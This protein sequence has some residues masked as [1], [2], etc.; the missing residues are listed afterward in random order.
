MPI[1]AGFAC[2][3]NQAK[4]RFEESA[5]RLSA[6]GAVISSWIFLGKHLMRRRNAAEFAKQDWDVTLGRIGSRIGLPW[7][8]K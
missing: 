4:V 1:V 5:V 3:E 7:L 6:G 8:L 2:S